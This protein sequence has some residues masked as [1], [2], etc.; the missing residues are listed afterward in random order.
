MKKWFSITA[1]TL[2]MASSFIYAKEQAN[3]R[4][5]YKMM[6]NKQYEKAAHKLHSL[7]KDYPQDAD[8]RYQLALS[9]LRLEQYEDAINEYKK[10]VELSDSYARY[11]L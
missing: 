7:V 3:L 5:V 10:T 6:D 1:I 2:L 8:A 11:D 9:L 4:S